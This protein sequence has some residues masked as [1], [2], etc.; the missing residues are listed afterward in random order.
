MTFDGYQEL[1][2]LHPNYFKPDPKALFDL[3]LSEDDPFIVL[4]F[5]S[6]SASHDVGQY[7][8][9]DKEEFVR[10]L[11]KYG[12]VFITSEAKLRKSFERYRINIGPEKM[13][14]LLYYATMY[15]G[16][17]ATMATE[18]GILGTPSIYISSLV[19]T[20]GN[21]EELEKRYNIVYSF[22]DS[23]DALK[24]A[25]QLLEENNLKRKWKNKRER[26]LEEKIDVTEFMT[27]FIENYQNFIR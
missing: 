1:A 27:G 17:G 18:S 7:G 5:V 8:I 9:A 15:V 20:M 14:D 24:K 16:E 2:Y 10:A 4:R 25:L 11:E 21:F 26:L 12:Q 6:W 22:R 3:E 13:H 19:G 23:K